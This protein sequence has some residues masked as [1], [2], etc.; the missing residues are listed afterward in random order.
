MTKSGS[1]HFTLDSPD[2][3]KLVFARKI[4]NDWISVIVL[5]EKKV[6]RPIQ[7]IYIILAIAVVILFALLIYM[8]SKYNNKH[9]EALHFQKAMNA[10]SDIYASM[11]LID[12]KNHSMEELRISPTLERAM[13]GVHE[14]SMNRRMDIAR[15]YA[16]ESSQAMLLQFLDFD[17]LEERL[18][19]TRSVSH[20]F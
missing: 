15:G 8:F 3:K 11:T 17:T 10:L 14:D 20:D 4:N 7:G 1:E 12:L 9:F 18:A 6:M 13:G 16:A 2:G 5:D 19:N